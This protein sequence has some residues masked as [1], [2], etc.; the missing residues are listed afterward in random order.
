[1][2]TSTSSVL[3]SHF[4]VVKCLPRHIVCFA[5]V[6]LPDDIFTDSHRNRCRSRLRPIKP[7]I[8]DL[9]PAWKFPGTKEKVHNVKMAAVLVPLCFVNKVPSILLTVRSS[10]LH[11][12]QG[13]VR[14]IL[15]YYLLPSFDSGYPSRFV[16][17]S[18][19]S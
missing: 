10:Q 17:G 16:C 18:K 15:W 11:G 7:G 19:S 3:L 4:A 14:Y 13:Q 6:S 9:R 5:S 8:A 1:M 2:I 12:Y